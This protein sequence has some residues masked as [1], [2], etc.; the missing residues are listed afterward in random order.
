M[1]LKKRTIKIALLSHQLDLLG[2]H[3][4]EMEP[5]AL[6]QQCITS[7]LK[8]CQREIETHIKLEEVK[9]FPCKML[10]NSLEEEKENL[11]K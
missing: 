11:M 6:S 8:F 3:L 1:L 10:I 4:I 5:E 7:F 9:Y 2:Q